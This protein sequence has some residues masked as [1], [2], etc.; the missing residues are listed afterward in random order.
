[1]FHLFNKRS[2]TGNRSLPVE[3]EERV[4]RRDSEPHPKRTPAKRYQ[5]DAKI[6]ELQAEISKIR[7]EERKKLL[8]W[9]EMANLADLTSHESN[10][11]PT[12][13]K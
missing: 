6:N 1:M 9:E 3:D 7:E 13:D 2:R 10:K 11:K 5:N 12:R 4:P 8:P